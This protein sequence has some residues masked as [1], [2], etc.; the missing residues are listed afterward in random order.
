MDWQLIEEESLRYFRFK[1]QNTVAIY[2]TG[3]GEDKFVRDFDPIFLH[4]VHSDIIIDVDV[5]NSRIGD[6]LISQRKNCVLGVKIADCLPVYLFNDKN[7]CIIHCGWRSIIR[8]IAK[9]AAALL[10]YYEYVTGASIGTC[11]YD[12]KEDVVELFDQNYA[13]S[14]IC[15]G[16][17]HFL[18]LKAAVREDL[19]K[20]NELASLDYCTK[21]HPMYFYSHRRGNSKKRNYA[22]LSAV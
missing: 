16:Q 3:V 15:R 8:G 2:T 21:C 19:G 22:V 7:I 20:K 4:Q 10:G 1:G 14:V 11:C 9:K 6:G 18:D 12:V 5:N 17:R 13:N